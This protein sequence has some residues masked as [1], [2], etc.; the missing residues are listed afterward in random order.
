MA[1]PLCAAALAISSD[2]HPLH[3]P[4]IHQNLKKSFAIDDDQ[5]TAWIVHWL[6]T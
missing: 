4:R 3:T 1:T 6:T 2:T 5:F